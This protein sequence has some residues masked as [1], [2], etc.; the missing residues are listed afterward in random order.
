MSAPPAGAA[1]P[2][3]DER[4]R[5][6]AELLVE[7]DREAAAEATERVGESAS[8]D[9]LP[10]LGAAQQALF[11]LIRTRHSALGGPDLDAVEQAQRSFVAEHGER[12]LQRRE[13][14]R[15]RPLPLLPARLADVTGEREGSRSEAPGGRATRDVCVDVASVAIDLVRAGEPLLSERLLSTFAALSDDYELYGVIDYLMRDCALRRIAE[16]GS[17][18]DELPQARAWLV[19]A[20]ATSAAP[21]VPPILVAVGGLV[22]SGKSTIARRIAERMG[23]PR[24]EADRARAFLVRG[25]E[26]RTLASDLEDLVYHEMVRR[27]QLV[28]GS[29]RPVV[30]DACFPRNSQRMLARALARAHDWPFLF[31]ECRVDEATTRARL[32]ARDA[33]GPH[34]GW[35]VMYDRLARRWEPVS[36]LAI[37]EHLLLDCARPV[38]ASD[39]VLARHVPAAPEGHVIP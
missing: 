17:I 35:R 8:A 18:A 7:R 23:A 10:E 11:A 30:L 15:L 22:A 38:E 2:L 24:V 39:E 29:G 14:G 32:A 19:L 16:L 1:G 9:V 27:A 12:F 31:V 34:R 36:G 5:R 25:D 33:E 26:V 37:E 21:V 13:A 28:L 4:V 20:K 3:T 6:I